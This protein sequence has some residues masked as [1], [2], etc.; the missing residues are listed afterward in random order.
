MADTYE[1]DFLADPTT[2]SLPEADVAFCLAAGDVSLVL[3]LLIEGTDPT[4]KSQ[5]LIRTRFAG[6]VL[7]RLFQQEKL[8]APTILQAIAQLPF[9]PHDYRLLPRQM[10]QMIENGIMGLQVQADEAWVKEGIEIEM[11]QLFKERN[12]AFSKQEV[13]FF[14]LRAKGNYYFYARSYLSA[15]KAFQEAEATWPGQLK[16]HK[17]KKRTDVLV[18]GTRLGLL[19]AQR[20]QK[21]LT[22]AQE[23]ERQAFLLPAAPILP[24]LEKIAVDEPTGRL[25]IQDR[26]GVL[27][28]D[29]SE[30]YL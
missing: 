19:L 28:E 14:R 12:K 16:E 17:L 29:A 8:P 1:Q 27:I 11:A 18:E 24:P 30:Q 7:V 23:E 22:P 26:N 5:K 21:Q 9:T 25:Q 15:W 6:A 2:F 4:D 10:A 3:Q 20:P 13:A